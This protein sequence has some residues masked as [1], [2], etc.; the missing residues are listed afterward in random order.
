MNIVLHICCGV[1][2]TAA[3]ERLIQEG[4]QVRGF[5]YNPNIHPREEYER[6]LAV[7][8]RVAQKMGFSLEAPP[9]MPEEWYSAAGMLAD[10]PEGG[11]RC[12]V[13]FRIRLMRTHVYLKE[14]GGDAFT[15]TL[16]T[17]PRKPAALINRIGK[18]TGG[19]SFLT[20]DFKK[21]EGHKRAMEFARKQDLYRQ[22]YCGC[23]YS[24]KQM[25]KVD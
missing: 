20:R 10:E 9:Y 21:K 24:L 12:E 11:R 4:H 7:A 25:S 19:D 2:A 8:H 16:T 18:E 5:F 15:T 22:K 17:G 3:A 14:W 6:R 23:V 1:C 13:C